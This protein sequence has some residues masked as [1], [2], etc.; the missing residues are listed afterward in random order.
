MVLVL[1]KGP[2]EIPSDV[3]GM[4]FIDISKGVDVAGERIRIEL[5]DWL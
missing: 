5:G 2:I 1:H 4:A 3:A